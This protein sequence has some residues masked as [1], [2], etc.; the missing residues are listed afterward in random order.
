MQ[1]TWSQV[2]SNCINVADAKALATSGFKR[3]VTAGMPF[4]SFLFS[5]ADEASTVK[6][7]CAYFLL[8]SYQ[9][10]AIQSCLSD[11]AQRRNHQSSTAEVK[12]HESMLLSIS[13]VSV[14]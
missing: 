7:L 1:E 14:G 12:Q 4:K 13:S 2:Q 6:L 11:R 3:T 10:M 5:D 8:S 9:V